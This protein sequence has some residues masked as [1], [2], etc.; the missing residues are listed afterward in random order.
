MRLSLGFLEATHQV[1]KG[2]STKEKEKILC[3]SPSFLSFSFWFAKSGHERSG[4]HLSVG[5]I[6]KKQGSFFKC[7]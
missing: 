1:F 7:I 3:I 5:N 2:S 6:Q 4:Q